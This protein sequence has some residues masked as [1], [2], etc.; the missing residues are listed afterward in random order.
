MI[1]VCFCLDHYFNTMARREQVAVQAA[2]PCTVQ[3][4]RSVRGVE[5]G[6]WFTRCVDGREPKIYEHWNFAEDRT[7]EV[8][9]FA[10]I[11]ISDDFIGETFHTDF[12]SAKGRRVTF[13]GRTSVNGSVEWLNVTW[14]CFETAVATAA[15]TE[16]LYVNPWR[17]TD[18]PA[19][20]PGNPFNLCFCAPF[21][22]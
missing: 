9:P 6:V 3:F 1:T 17:T 4:L 13:L 11:K 5:E 16:N 15:W 19:R 20:I 8:H 14:H 2:P 7:C 22:R 18:S 10:R 12:V 21:P